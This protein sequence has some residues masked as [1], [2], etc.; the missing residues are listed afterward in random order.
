MVQNACIFGQLLLIDHSIH[1]SGKRNVQFVGILDS[2]ADSQAALRIRINKQ[3]SVSFVC[4]A[5]TEIEGSSCLS[6]TA[7]NEA[8][9]DRVCSYGSKL[10]SF[11]IDCNRTLIEYIVKV[12]KERKLV[13]P[14]PTAVAVALWPDTIESYTDCYSFVDVKGDHTYGQTC[15]DYVNISEKSRN[16]RVV[17]T[18]DCAL[19]KKIAINKFTANA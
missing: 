12:R 14:D 1:Y 10:S 16:V 6:D 8:E 3:D 4:E 9:I 19:F 2:E 15:F 11:V 13:M 18:M 5:Y 17:D 7:F